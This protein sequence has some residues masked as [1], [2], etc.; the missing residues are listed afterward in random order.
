MIRLLEM[1]PDH[2]NLN[3]DLANSIVLRKQFE[4]RGFQVEILKYRPGDELPGEFDFFV[5][6]HGSA[7]AWSSIESDFKNQIAKLTE[8]LLRSV[9][10]IVIGNGFEATAKA[11]FGIDFQP[12]PRRS[13]F[14][15]ANVEGQEILGYVNSATDLPL[16]LWHRNVLGT[17][18]HG[19]VLAKN[20]VL[21]DRFIADICH[22]RGIA[23]RPIEMKN[24][25][26]QMT[27][28]VERVWS[29]EKGLASE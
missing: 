23:N 4:M 2:L 21:V 13:E 11:L 16:A 28:L 10:G 27:D 29:L 15:I 12:K 17:L 24:E 3:G 14:A 25:A 18:L 20:P 22:R 7:A 8:S 6:G 26:D 5:I 9:S 19:P 1:Y